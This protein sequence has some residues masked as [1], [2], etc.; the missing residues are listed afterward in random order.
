PIVLYD[1]LADRWFISQFGLPNYPNGPFYQ[2]IAVS[3]TGD[4]T[5]AWHRY[6]FVVSDT[7]LND[8][9]HFGVWPD[10]YYMTINQ[11][12]AAASWGGAGVAVYERDK[13]L[14]GQSAR[15]VYFDLYS[16]NSNYGGMLPSD[17]DG[18][19]PPTGTPNYFAEVDD[20]SWIGS[21]DAMR[22]WEFHVDWANTSNSTFGI[23][24]NPNATLIIANFNPLYSDIPQPS[25]SQRLDNLADRLM[26][27]LQYRSVGTHETLVTNHTVDVGSGRAGVRWYEAQ[28]VSSSWNIHQQGT[29][30]G[31]G[32]NSNHRWMG[33]AAMDSAGNIAIGYSLS[34][35]SVYPSIA[36]T[37]R[38][39]NDP[40]NTMPQGE[41]ILMAGSGSQTHYAGRWGDYSMLGV[42]PSDNC[43]FWFTSEYLSTTG[44]A[45]WQTRIGSFTFPSCLTGLKGTLDGH[46]TSNSLPISN[47]TVD[48][49]GFSTTTGGDG[50]YQFPELPVGT[51]TVT[52]S[53]YGYQSDTVTN[54]DIIFESTTTQDFNLTPTPMVNVS[55][56]VSD[57]SGQGWPLYARIDISAPG[58]AQTIFSD[59]TTGA[60]SV[61]LAQGT[62]HTFEVNAIT[63]GYLPDSISLT[64][65]SGG[66]TQNFLL[67]VDTD[68]CDAPGYG[69]TGTCTALPGGLVQ[70]NVYDD[71]TGAGINDATVTND[72]VPTEFASTFATPEDPT[73]DDGF[74]VLF[75]SLIGPHNFTASRLDYGESTQTVNVVSSNIAHQNF[76]LPAGML[77][78][79][80]ISLS[81]NLSASAIVTRVITL[82]NTGSYTTTFDLG[83]VNA[84]AQELIPTGPFAIPNR[85]TSPKHLA[86]LDSSAVYEYNPPAV[87]QH[88]G[89][90]VLQTWNSGLD[91]I[92]GIGYDT[93][94]EDIWVGNVAVGGGDDMLYRFQLGGSS[95]GDAIDS[96]STAAYFAADMTYNPFTHTFWQV[97]VSGGNCL[98]EIDPV[99]GSL[100]G[101]E[102]CPT[103]DNSQRGLAYN[104]LDGTYFSGS[105]TNGILYHFTETGIILDSVDINLNTAGLAF[106]PAT[107]H[108]FVLTN[109][110]IG[111]DVY[112]LDTDDNYTIIGGYSIPGL[113]DFAGAGMSMDCDGHLWIANQI[114]QQVFE[115]DSGETSPC[116]FADIPWLTVSP[117]NGSLPAGDQEEL[118]FTIDA[119]AS[120]AGH[121]QA[122]VIITNDTPYGSP[123]IPVEIIVQAEYRVSADPLADGV[124]ANPGST[125]GYTLKVTNIGNATDL[126]DISI[127]GNL[128]QVSLPSQI[129]PLL[130]SADTH[131][132]VS[133]T[134]PS[135]ANPGDTDTV[136][137]KVTSHSNPS[138]F[139]TATL[140]T[141][142]SNKNNLYLPSL[143][144]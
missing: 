91:H 77:E 142:T 10:G 3:Q 29:Y 66:N 123:V 12:T 6:A 104:P 21:D 84:A 82:T 51:Y 20:S 107:R 124:T 86:D 62:L 90:A 26:H 7:K 38:L 97:N 65:T 44:N 92:W 118:T 57:G 85:H 95:T 88:P 76:S 63:P 137:V 48:A 143:S 36:Y 17:L 105:W 112:V 101:R 128:W 141:T 98:V 133:V 25:T 9:P 103:F 18:P 1:H 4:P 81:E 129:G 54:I 114:T 64:P 32:S 121:S 131:F 139:T 24:G 71:N 73:V 60:Y 11:F 115:V 43:T 135:D 37:G 140:T 108:L 69:D 68:L 138:A 45:P 130:A 59:P 122:Q 55:G 31:D 34:S 144:K 42:D 28:K 78:V 102:I 119:S 15:Q 5:G 79:S 111:F 136:F 14:L 39:S 47:A 19:P 94:R 93:T 16:V 23:S 127:S 80:P 83:E 67:Y 41:A 2:C 75:S 53:A 56:T 58:S 13:M 72:E 61:E 109:A 132:E 87:N 30:A 117:V 106:N 113:G 120:Q 126:Y 33:S 22:I 40:L 52:V 27:R 134:I 116:N 35:G 110:E 100:T 50:F 99:Q 96:A 125:V 89:G 70:G 74:Y 49:D 46:V 8:Y